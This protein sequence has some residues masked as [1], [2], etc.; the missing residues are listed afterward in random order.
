MKAQDFIDTD[1]ISQSPSSEDAPLNQANPEKAGVYVS[2][3]Q[4]EIDSRVKEARQQILE[5]RRQ[6]EELEKVRQE[7]EDLR[8][9]Q[10]DFEMGK[11]EM[12]EELSRA[13]TAIEQEEFEL[14]QKSSL[15]TNFRELFQDYVRQLQAIR[16]SEWERDE[17]KSQLAKAVSVVEAARAELNKGRAQLNFLGSD[18]IRSRGEAIAMPSSLLGGGNGVLPFSFRLEF[19]RGLARSM[20]LIIFGLLA[21]IFI[22]MRGK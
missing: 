14:N 8:N 10:E 22:L 7:L 9:R 18:V 4:A 17:L 12:L 13:I 2:Q 20:P 16:D 5:L 11:T 21:L 6:Q 19:Q 1:I 3:S 15:L